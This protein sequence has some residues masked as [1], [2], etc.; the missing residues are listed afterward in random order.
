[1]ARCMFPCKPIISPA[2]DAS[3]AGATT[4]PC[5]PSRSRPFAGLAIRRSSSRLAAGSAII[6]PSGRVHR[7]ETSP[8]GFRVGI[9]Y[10]THR[11]APGG[12]LRLGGLTIP[13]D[14]SSVGH[15]DADVLLHAL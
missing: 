13:H 1:M 4:G 8:P 7:K 2:Q 10:D 11:L 5:R 12:P 14:K 6:P 9:G 15:S 3:A